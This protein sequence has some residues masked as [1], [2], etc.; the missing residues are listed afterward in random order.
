VIVVVE[1]KVV[2]GGGSVEVPDGNAHR[3]IRGVGCDR[4]GCCLRSLEG[5]LR[6]RA[7]G[8]CCSKV[9]RL[10]GGGT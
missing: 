8:S 4:A 10:T 3:H 1:G 2:S 5:S 7:G 9:R 6:G